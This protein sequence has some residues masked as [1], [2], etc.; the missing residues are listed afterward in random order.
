M[1]IS[2]TCACGA[3]LEIDEK[4]LGKE[5]PCPDCGKPLPTKAPP[6]PPPLELPNHRRLSVL[7]ILSLTFGLVGLLVPIVGATVAVALGILAIAQIRNSKKLD[8]INMARAGIAVGALSGVL[9]IVVLIFPF[10]MDFVLREM[11]MLRFLSYATGESIESRGGSILIKRPKTSSRWGTLETQ[12]QNNVRDP[13]DLIAVNVH[14]DAYMA[15]MHTPRDILFDDD[16]IQK[17]VLEQ[18]ARS[19]LVSMLG[20]LNG[21]PA[22]EPTPIAPSVVD[23]AKQVGEMTVDMRLGGIDRRML[24]LYKTNDRLRTH[25]F[26]GCAR[27]SR[28][29]SM[30]AEFREAFDGFKSTR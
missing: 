22:P 9:G 13:D 3:R 30:Q 7:A 24:V 23:K 27:R 4:F 14:A 17:S 5:V 19:E 11:A 10:G 15:C 8:G 25:I 21:Q 1:P 18:L 29:D 20:R 12:A 16:A 6:T 2:V 26:V 28:F